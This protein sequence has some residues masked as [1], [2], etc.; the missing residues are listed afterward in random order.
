MRIP[1]ATFSLLSVDKAEFPVLFWFSKPPIKTGV[2]G[3][4][5]CLIETFTLDIL[6]HLK[7]A[8]TL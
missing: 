1:I 7:D 8:I 4:Y 6:R 5:A 3:L 2:T